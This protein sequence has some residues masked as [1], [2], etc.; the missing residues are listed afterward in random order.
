MAILSSLV[1]VIEGNWD[2]IQGEIKNRWGKLTDDDLAEIDGSYK[3]LIGKL[4]KTYGYTQDEIEDKLR[5]FSDKL[6]LENAKDMVEDIQEKITE[7]AEK[8]WSI[9]KNKADEF[10]DG[11]YC[12]VRCNPF[13]S[14]G[15]VSAA[16]LLSVLAIKLFK[17][18][19]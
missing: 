3:K 19:K 8:A 1:H 14:M 10:Q 16:I 12:Y 7:N 18:N 17:K 6:N 13:R 4:E 15:A 11:I 2:E 5:I 9:V